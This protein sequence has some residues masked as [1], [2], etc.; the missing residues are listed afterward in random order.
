MAA[1][2]LAAMETGSQGPEGD[3]ADAGAAATETR[4]PA[5][6]RAATE[7]LLPAAAVMEIPSPA[8]GE[9]R[10]RGAEDTADPGSRATGA[11]L[12]R[13]GHRRMADVRKALVE[14]TV[15]DTDRRGNWR[16]IIRAPSGALAARSAGLAERHGRGR[17]IRADLAADTDHRR[18]SGEQPRRAAHSA[19]DG[20]EASAAALARVVTETR[21]ASRTHREDLTGLAAAIVHP[22]VSGAGTR[23][24]PSVADTPLAAADTRLVEADTHSVEAATRSAAVD[25]HLVEAAIRS[26]VGTAEAATALAGGMAVDTV[27]ADTPAAVDIIIEGRMERLRSYRTASVLSDSLGLTEQLLQVPSTRRCPRR[28]MSA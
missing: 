15:P 23:R 2:D 3:T 1:L 8:A 5:G 11:C 21:L 25:T 18:R 24:Q 26:E 12:Q 19:A 20:Q 6:V 9:I 17:V 27:E 13:D 10:L 22:R 16:R 14:D 7:I 28:G 4:L